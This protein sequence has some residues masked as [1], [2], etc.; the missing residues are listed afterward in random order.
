LI[1]PTRINAVSFADARRGWAVGAGGTVLST[2]D[3]GRTWRRQQSDTDADLADVKFLDAREG[4]A[5]G[6]NGT[7]IH[8]TDGGATWS[9]VASGTSHPLERLA[10]ASPTRGWAVGFGG[11]IIAYAPSTSAPPR[12][13]N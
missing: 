10:F 13:K 11:T 1:K 5:V 6:A 8:T 2:A 3:G 9:N 12:M 7:I 4:W